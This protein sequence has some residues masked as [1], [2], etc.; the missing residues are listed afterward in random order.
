MRD[1]RASILLSARAF[2]WCQTLLSTVE[3]YPHLVDIVDTGRIF[4]T[5]KNQVANASYFVPATNIIF[6]R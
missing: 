6:H 2:L 5:L 1:F 3:D 4:N